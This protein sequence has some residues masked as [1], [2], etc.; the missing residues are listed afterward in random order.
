MMFNPICKRFAPM[1]ALLFASLVMSLQ[2]CHF[3][4]KSADLIVHNARIYT[5]DYDFSTAEAMAVKDGRI[6]AI[7]PEREIMNE[8]DAPE[9]VDAQKKIVMPGLIDAH[10]HFMAYG[11]GRQDA[12][13]I[14]LASWPAV[15]EALQRYAP[16]RKSEWVLGRGWDQND[17]RQAHA[18]SIGWQGNADTLVVPFPDR[19]LLDSLFPN[20]P[21][22][23]TR[24]DG[25]AGL[26]NGEAL[27]RAGITPS[28]VIPGGLVE[29]EQ[30]RCTGILIDNAMGWVERI[31]PARTR[32]EKIAALVRAQEDCFRY[33]LT[34]VDEAGLMREDVELI[35]SLQKTGALNMRVY[36]MLSDD[37][38]NV[39]YY[40]NKGIDTSNAMLHVRSFKF[41]G[42]GALGSRGACLLSP[43][44]DILL[45]YRRQEYGMLLRTPDYYRRMAVLLYENGWQ[46][47]THAIGDS[48]NRTILDIYGQILAGTND[49]RWRIEH[50]QVV[51]KTDIEKFARFSVIPSV[52]PT[53][54]T[55]DMGWAWE[56][57][58]RNRVSRAYAYKELKGQLGMVALGTDFP[59]EDISPVATFC[60][61][62]FRTNAMGQPGGGFQFEN[63]L[64]R[65]DALRGMTIWAAL[66]NFQEHDRGSLEV[67]KRSDFVIVDRDWMKAEEKGVRSTEVWATYV[68][69][70][71]VYVKE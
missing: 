16:G 19:A 35:D 40:I 34:T 39:A 56:R 17:W 23:L 26:A 8:Y 60:S 45:K 21:V 10:C 33:G 41:Y 12:Q 32:E 43:Y 29:I 18:A 44:E 57:L 27:R 71:L 38:S 62:V 1:G 31:I 54:A 30:G 47:N 7:G 46:M 50:A 42:D 6:I 28:T 15:L 3:Q 61:A 55:S 24:I 11:L 63:A 68:G 5:V 20:T 70:K 58:G 59:V 37:S 13:L 65:E 51:A 64:T 4:N 52:Q 22:Y 2:A 36:A 48:A 25:H 9:I 67:G 66:A 49:R 53:H 14:G 69:G